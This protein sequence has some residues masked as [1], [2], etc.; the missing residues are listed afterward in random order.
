ME[1]EEIMINFVNTGADEAILKSMSTEGCSEDLIKAMNK[2]GL[3]QKDVTVQGKNGKTFTRKQWV[4]ASDAKGSQSTSQS[5]Q[6]SQQSVDDIKVGQML[7]LKGKT[8]KVLKV[9]SD[10]FTVKNDQD[11]V[12]KISKQYVSDN[13]GK[14]PSSVKSNQSASK[15]STSTKTADKTDTTKSGS[16]AWQK[17][18]E[19]A[20]YSAPGTAAD[21]A[22]GQVLKELPKGT[23]IKT[24]Q[25][26]LTASPPYELEVTYT[27]GDYDGW[28]YI[29]KDY[30]TVYF[31]KVSKSICKVK[32]NPKFKLSVEVPE[33]PAK[34]DSDTSF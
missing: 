8:F 10:T 12:T 1:M 2:Q 5:S 21:Y 26:A 29:S 6:S 7:H 34:S 33:P 20:L 30:D 32:D 25:K 11:I 23:V 13:L 28:Q 3:V 27:K 15:Q 14:T 22:V 19:D 16:A 4:K 31:N 24:G 18:L 9:N 17:K